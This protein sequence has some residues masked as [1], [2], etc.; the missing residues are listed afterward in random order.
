MNLK[1]LAI[2]SC[3]LAL[4]FGENSPVAIG[5]VREV[6]DS[7]KVSAEE[8]NAESPTTA[9]PDVAQRIVAAT[10]QFRQE[11][12]L[13][14]VEVDPQLEA[15]A[16]Y[17]AQYMARTNIYGHAADGNRPSQRATNHGYDYC[18]VSENIAYAYNSLGFQPDELSRQFVRGWQ[19]SPEHR[20]NMLDPEVTHTGVAIARSDDS[21]YHYAVQMFG[22][23]TSMRIEFR[24][25]NRSDREVTYK[26]DDRTF[27]LA[28]RFIRTHQRCRPATLNIQLADQQDLKSVDP[29]N[30]DTVMI[31]RMDGRLRVKVD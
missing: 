18:I 23:P 26:I 1:P 27:P 20:E 24:V 3:I 29:S 11:H 12:E 10:N 30:G 14:A 4:P 31:E 28:S 16:K 6:T 25:V 17:F 9:M 2:A 13:P 21:R 8:G 19:E 22:R 5:Q 15:A 7:E